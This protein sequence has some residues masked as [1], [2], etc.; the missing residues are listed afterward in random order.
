MI[1]SL[2]TALT[3]ILSLVTVAFAGPAKYGG[4]KCGNHFTD[5]EIAAKERNFSG[6]IN[7]TEALTRITN[8]FSNHTVLVYFNVI[9]SGGTL[10]QGCVP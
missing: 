3:V 9:S 7:N 4:R 6:A 2:P 10:E 1:L 5:E 8:G